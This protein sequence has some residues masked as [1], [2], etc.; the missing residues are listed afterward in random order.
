MVFFFSLTHYSLLLEV[1]DF[2]DVA[3]PPL[4]QESGDDGRC[5]PEEKRVAATKC[6]RSRWAA[7]LSSCPDSSAS[8]PTPADPEVA[9]RPGALT[10]DLSTAVLNLIFLW[11]LR[12][13]LHSWSL[14]AVQFV[15]ISNFSR[16]FSVIARMN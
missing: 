3:G 2:F 10:E 8:S 12:V 16:V 4:G 15:V 5:T 1:V 13:I 14:C 11:V 9:R 7:W 6:W